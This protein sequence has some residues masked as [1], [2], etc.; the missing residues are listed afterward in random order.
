MSGSKITQ[1]KLKWHQIISE[2]GNYKLAEPNYDDVRFVTREFDSF[3]VL[4][5]LYI[6]NDGEIEEATP[7]VWEDSEFLRCDDLVTIMFSPNIPDMEDD[8]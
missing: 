6:N 4:F 7:E 3:G 2:I 5:T 8:I 1:E